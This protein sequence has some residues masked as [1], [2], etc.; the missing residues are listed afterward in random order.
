MTPKRNR[1]VQPDRTGLSHHVTLAPHVDQTLFD[2]ARK[3]GRSLSDLVREAVAMLLNERQR[4]QR[5]A[6]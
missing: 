2:L 4:R 6:E 3:E 5:M 1:K